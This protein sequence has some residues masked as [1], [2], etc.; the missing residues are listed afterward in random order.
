MATVE[1]HPVE[2]IASNRFSCFIKG[3]IYYL[4][5]MG[6][7]NTCARTKKIFRLSLTAGRKIPINQLSHSVQAALQAKDIPVVGTWY[8]ITSLRAQ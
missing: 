5:A 1:I 2:A 3:F 8:V 7:C 6:K 4:P